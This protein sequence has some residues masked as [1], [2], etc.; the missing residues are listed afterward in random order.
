M[1]RRLSRA[2]VVLVTLMPSTKSLPPLVLISLRESKPPA[3]DLARPPAPSRPAVSFGTPTTR[4]LVGCA[5]GSRII[6]NR[7]VWVR[8]LFVLFFGLLFWVYIVLW[9]VLK[10]MPQVQRHQTLSQPKDRVRWCLWWFSRL[11]QDRFLN[12]R[13]IFLLPLFFNVMGIY[14]FSR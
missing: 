6:S 7:P 1:W 11:L 8:I 2:L 5:V 13:L 9:I 14:H 4:Q 10:S 3:A 12:A